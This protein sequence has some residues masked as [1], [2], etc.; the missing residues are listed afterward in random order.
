MSNFRPVIMVGAGGTGSHLFHPLIQ[1]LGS[2][3]DAM[4]HIYDEDHVTPENLE[5]QLFYSH[6]VGQNKAMALAARFPENAIGHSV[7]IGF[8]NVDKIIQEG[9]TVLICADNMAVRRLINRRAKTLQDILVINGGNEEHSASVQVFLREGGHNITPPLDFYSP[10]FFLNDGPDRS[11]LSCAQLARLPGGG[12]TVVA[13]ATAANLILQALA[14][15]DNDIYLLE[16]QWTK[17]TV[18]I[19]QG[20]VQTSDVRLIGGYDE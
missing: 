16:G 8:K 17:Q 19:F 6:E 4:V 7:F 5:R 15:V 18:D 20:T 1:Y 13:N 3:G 10:E 11:T 12:Q 14:R 9:D 2:A